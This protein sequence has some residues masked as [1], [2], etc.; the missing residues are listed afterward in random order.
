MYNLKKIRKERELTQ[1]QVAEFL[2]IKQS[3]IS[4][5]ENGKRVLTM[6]TVEKLCS[7]YGCSYQDLICPKI[8]K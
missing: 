4:H 1:E 2:G 7:F 5:L 6:P 3:G 8:K